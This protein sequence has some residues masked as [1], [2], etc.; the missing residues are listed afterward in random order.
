MRKTYII[1]VDG[2]LLEQIEDF[3]NITRY[4]TIPALPGAREN[5]TRWH[6][7]GHY[8]ILITARPESL[9]DITKEQLHNAGVVY[10]LLIMGVGAGPRVS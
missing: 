9:R 4:R 5:T 2:S 1:D 7:E 8:I 6:C 10:D 3:E